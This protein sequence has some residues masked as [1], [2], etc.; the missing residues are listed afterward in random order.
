MSQWD[1]GNQSGYSQSFGSQSGY[2]QPP[3]P[4]YVPGPAAYGPGFAPIDPAER[5]RLQTQAIILLITG[6]LCGGM[7]PVIFGIIALTQ[8]DTNPASARSMIK[9]GWIIAIVLFLIGL[10]V[11]IFT[12]GLSLLPMIIMLFTVPASS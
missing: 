9:I 2:Q 3:Q 5:S 10:V 4:G 12:F 8:L 6:V 1:Q 7:I 11:F